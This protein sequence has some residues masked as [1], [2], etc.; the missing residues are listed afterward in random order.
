MHVVRRF[1]LQQAHMGRLS[2]GE[3]IIMALES[4]CGEHGIQAGWVQLLGALNKATLG[5]VIS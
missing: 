5:R 3:D 2:Q 4:Y 1:N